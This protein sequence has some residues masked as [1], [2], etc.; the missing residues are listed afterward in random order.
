MNKEEHG[1]G[2]RERRQKPGRWRVVTEGACGRECLCASVF[3]VARVHRTLHS[4]RVLRKYCVVGHG[5]V[6]IQFGDN[7]EEFLL[8]QSKT[9]ES[10]SRTAGG[11]VAQVAE[12][13]VWL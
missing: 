5:W 3:R 4:G 12:E 13:R 9:L 6:H 11:L 10:L 7:R 2:S 8:A 1:T